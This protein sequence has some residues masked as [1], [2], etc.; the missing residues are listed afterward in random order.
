[1]EC[2]QCWLCADFRR[3]RRGR[4]ANSSGSCH[5]CS[6]WQTNLACGQSRFL[7]C[8]G[9][10]PHG[11]SESV[12]GVFRTVFVG[13]SGPFLGPTVAAITLGIVGAAAFDKQFGKNQA[14]NAAGNVFT[15]LL[16]A[17]VSYQFGYR[18]IFAVA[19]L[20][21]I[22]AA[23]SLCFIDARQ[24]DYARARGGIQKQGKIAAEG[25][26]VLLKDRILIYFLA[27][28]FLFHLADAAMLP[29]LGEMLSKDNLKAAAPFMSA[30]IIVTQFVIAISATWIGR[31]AAAKGRK[32]LLLLGFGVLPIRGVLYTLTH[33][34]GAL[35]AI[36]TL[37]G[38]AN[39]IFGIVSILVVKDRTQGTGRFNVAAGSLA[40]MVG[41][42]AALSTAIGGVLIQHR[43]YRASFFGLAG[44]A[45][46]AFAVLW[47]AIP[48]TLRDAAVK[49]T[50][51]PEIKP[52]PHG[53]VGSGRTKAGE[54]GR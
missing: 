36:Q 28:A 21:A 25:W 53:S 33:A 5:R 50:V 27:T 13:G 16:V 37:D 52:T 45:L 23:I 34:V 8:R 35:I 32:P 51:G 47:F 17:Y 6:A 14:F 30:C 38:V 18:A 49:T 11:P 42:G 22:P 10:P 41:V 43:G 4:N 9:A 2:R 20:L 48:E 24:I 7:G 3:P 29:E 19:A 44:I 31:R 1:M 15:A 46:L 39:A 12:A 54:T 40:T 26:S